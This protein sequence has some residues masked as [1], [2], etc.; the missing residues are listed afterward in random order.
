M[1]CIEVLKLNSPQEALYD[2][3]IEERLQ[4]KNFA[5]IR[6]SN[7]LFKKKTNKKIY[8]WV[9]AAAEDGRTNYQNK[10]DLDDILIKPRLLSKT[11]QIFSQIF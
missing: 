7:F 1:V 3:F 9:M 8:D 5:T 10:N 11:I 4:M 6:Q 2:I